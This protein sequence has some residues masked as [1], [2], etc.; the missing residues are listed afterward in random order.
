MCT[1]CDKCGH[2]S[3]E[4]KSGAGLSNNNLINSFIY[5]LFTHSLFFS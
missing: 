1:V 2:R 4:V 3:N 5:I